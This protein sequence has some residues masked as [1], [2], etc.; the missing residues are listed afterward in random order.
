M[1]NDPIVLPNRHKHF[2]CFWLSLSL[3]LYV[4]F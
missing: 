4:G 3:L 1:K 2:C